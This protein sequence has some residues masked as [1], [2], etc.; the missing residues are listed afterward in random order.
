[1]ADTSTILDEV[2]NYLDAL[3]TDLT[4]FS[5]R[6]RAKIITQTL[7]ALDASIRVAKQFEAL[8]TQATAGDTDND[9]K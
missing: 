8:D 3:L 9:T 5:T 1:M 6:R 2:Y 4:P 7:D